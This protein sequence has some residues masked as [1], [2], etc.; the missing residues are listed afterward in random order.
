VCLPQPRRLIGIAVALAALAIALA[1]P[2]D[3]RA[4]LTIEGKSDFVL[5]GHARTISQGFSSA[6][7]DPIIRVV[8][9]RNVTIKNLTLVGPNRGVDYVHPIEWQH[10]IEVLGTQGVR[11]VNVRIRDV[12]GDG[13]TLCLN[14][15]PGGDVCLGEPTRGV[16]IRDVDIANVGRQGIAVV[17]GEHIRIQRVAIHDVRPGQGTTWSPTWRASR[18]A[19]STWSAAASRASPATPSR[20]RAMATP[21]SMT[22]ALRATSSAT[23]S[24]SPGT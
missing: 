24:C 2:A 17:A 23:T 20:Y 21:G 7:N 5:D 6:P 15:P 19:T 8:G 11:I 1:V 18:C 16:Q 10:G 22:C 3:A 9:G 12:F 14:Q 13:I 4:T